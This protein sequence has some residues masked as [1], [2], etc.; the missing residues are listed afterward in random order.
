MGK[1]G[2]ALIVRLSDI[3]LK[4]EKTNSRLW[5]G[6]KDK[7]KLKLQP[8]KWICKNILP[9]EHNR[10]CLLKICFRLEA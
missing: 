2:H 9:T 10:I 5:E 3:F 6:D 7:D 8:S 1:V 4:T